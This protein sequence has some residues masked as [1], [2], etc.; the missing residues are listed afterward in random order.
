MLLGLILALSIS[1]DPSMAPVQVDFPDGHQVDVPFPAQVNNDWGDRPYDLIQVSVS[2]RGDAAAVNFCWVIPKYRS[3]LVRLVRSDGSMS[4][5]RNSEVD[6]LTWSGDGKYLIGAGASTLRIWN[7][8]GSLQIS[9]AVSKARKYISA[10][11]LYIDEIRVDKSVV[12]VFI[13]GQNYRRNK[14]GIPLGGEL[15]YI[16]TVVLKYKIPQLS[17]ISAETIKRPRS[18][19][20]KHNTS[21]HSFSSLR[22]DIG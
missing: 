15:S 7:L 8:G 19:S 2:P 21:L 4:D 22:I 6:K 12:S 5:L 11:H 14:H 16:K 18:T 3:C 9:E 10:D 20:P 1:T 17:F 13:A